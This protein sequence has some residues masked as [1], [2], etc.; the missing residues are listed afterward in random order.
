MPDKLKTVLGFMALFLAPFLCLCAV[1]LLNNNLIWEINY[2]QN[3]W[4]NYLV[5]LLFHI[6]I[7]ALCGSIRFTVC[8]V[9]LLMLIFGLVNMYC[10][11]YKGSPLLP[12]D[13]GSW[14]TALHVAGTFEYEITYAVVF[15]V[16]AVAFSIAFAC[17]I[18]HRKTTLLRW[19]GRAACLGIFTGIA[20]FY[21]TTDYMAEEYGVAPDF[22]N[23]SRGY[24]NNGAIAEFIVNTKYLSLNPPKGYNA[25]NIEQEIA[26]ALKEPPLPI[27]VSALGQQP[28]APE[29]S[30]NIIVIMDEAFSDLSVIG[31]FDTN[32]D[33]MP[34]L[35]SLVGTENVIEGN[36][37]V[38]TIGTGTSN[39]EYEFLTG[40]SMAFLPIGSNAYQLYIDH[41]QPGL[42]ATL[43]GQGYSA[44]ALHPYYSSSWNRIAVYNYMGFDAFIAQDQLKNTRILRRFISDEYDFQQIIHLYEERDPN[45]PFYLFN[46]TMQNHS[47]YE[48]V[49]PSFEQEVTLEGIENKYPQTEQ[50]L[51]LI[52]VTDEALASLVDYFAHVEQP[53]ILLF[54]GDHQPFIENGFYQ[55]VMGEQLNKLSDERNQQ[56]YITRFMLWANYDIPEGWIDEISVNYLSPL[57]L[58]NTGLEMTE[59]TRFLQG[60]FAKVPVITALGC[61]DKDGRYYPADNPLSYIEDINLYWKAAYN[62][63]REDKKRANALFYVNGNN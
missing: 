39:T 63:L 56:R 17:W 33:Y 16:A 32:I 57:L 27:S 44:T 48:K 36:A 1:E 7:Y 58:E 59:Y 8:L 42:T 9:D 25:D 29:T 37:Y 13:F 14:R 5:F 28:G 49:Y 41:E 47:S 55:E 38:S 40:N 21:Y 31:D 51:S 52:K 22:F 62:N 15:A 45:E 53:T 46:I 30:P 19:V 18:P 35:N 12:W 6:G 23:Q 3:V 54:F 34:Y 11:L 61:R 2:A 43:K 26:D 50:Y 24:E 20:I 10:K 4:M 60:M